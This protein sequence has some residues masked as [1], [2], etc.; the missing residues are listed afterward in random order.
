MFGKLDGYFF[1]PPRLMA[2]TFPPEI[3]RVDGETVE[4]SISL[5]DANPVPTINWFVNFEKG[6]C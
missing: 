3:Q 6:N 5:S 2:E 4:L 1:R